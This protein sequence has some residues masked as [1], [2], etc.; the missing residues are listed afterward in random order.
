MTTHPLQMEMPRRVAFYDHEDQ[1]V[2]HCLE[3][4]LVG[5]GE[6]RDEALKLLT[7]ALAPA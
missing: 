4:D 2:A 3:F 6:T 1:W 5:C 7:D